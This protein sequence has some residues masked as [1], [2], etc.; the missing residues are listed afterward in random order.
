MDRFAARAK[1]AQEAAVI[2]GRSTALRVALNGYAV[3]ERRGG[4]WRDSATWT[5]ERGTQPD[6]AQGV[7]VQ[8]VFDTTGIADPLELTLRRADQRMQV[9][10][11]S[12]GEVHVRR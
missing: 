2:N 5:W 1:A 6:L 12:D 9:V 10:I 7:T 8:T 11:G 3:A 4:D